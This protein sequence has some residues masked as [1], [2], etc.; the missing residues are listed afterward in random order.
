MQEME[1]ALTDNMAVSEM[2]WELLSSRDLSRCGC[3][4]I[5]FCSGSVSWC[6]G[7]RR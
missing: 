6:Q 5:S 7:K 4:R 1:G 2:S 3:A